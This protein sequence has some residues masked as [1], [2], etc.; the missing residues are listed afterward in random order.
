MLYTPGTRKRD[1]QKVSK[2]LEQTHN[3]Q[4]WISKAT[5]RH[6]EMESLYSLRGQWVCRMWWC[7]VNSPK[8]LRPLLGAGECWWLTEPTAVTLPNLFPTYI[9]RSSTCAHT[10]LHLTPTPSLQSK[11]S[12]KVD[13]SAAPVTSHIK[14]LFP[15]FFVVVVIH[16]LM[17]EQYWLSKSS[18]ARLFGY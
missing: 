7:L 17:S 16:H 12:C 14:E 15:D 10:H 8:P 4:M 1:K 2:S 11:S 18:T 6:C 13:R 5:F 3:K 9:P